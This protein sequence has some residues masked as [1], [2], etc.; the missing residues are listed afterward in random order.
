MLLISP[1]LASE[2]L[3]RLEARMPVSLISTLGENA[4]MTSPIARARRKKGKLFT[5]FR[6][7]T[8]RPMQAKNARERYINMRQKS[9]YLNTRGFSRRG[10]GAD[11]D[12][13]CD[14][15]GVDSLGSGTD[16]KA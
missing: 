16:S 4:M 15:T 13:G 2:L 9:G 5:T 10:W 12:T 14:T 11:L 3:N 6:G 8:I 1:H 7:A